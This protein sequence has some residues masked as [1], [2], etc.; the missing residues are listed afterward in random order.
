[1]ITDRHAAGERFVDWL[2]EVVASDATGVKRSTLDLDPC[3]LFWLG[4]LA[5]EGEIAESKLGERAE[6]LEP[7]AVGMRLAPNADFGETVSFELRASFAVWR[8]DD[9]GWGKSVPID[10]SETMAISLEAGSKARFADSIQRKLD[11]RFPGSGLAAAFEV[12]TVASRDGSPELTVTLVNCSRP[13]REQKNSFARAR[14]FEC[15]LKVSGLE[16]REFVLEALPDSFR[17]DRHVPAWGVNCG[18]SVEGA[19]FVTVDLP[20]H[21][22]P[23]PQFWNVP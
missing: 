10:C 19:T 4:R 16:T 11:D 20:L 23:R 6:R 8:N 22:K 13:N 7:C 12:E 1:V 3:G 2:T 14:L 21:V 9:G 15:V 5:P 17:Y 18:V